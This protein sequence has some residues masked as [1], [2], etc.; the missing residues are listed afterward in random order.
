MS[1]PWLNFHW[2][3]DQCLAAVG[4][5]S[6]FSNFQFTIDSIVMDRRN[7]WKLP[8]DCRK[9]EGRQQ[10]HSMVSD[11]RVLLPGIFSTRFLGGNGCTATTIQELIRTCQQEV[12][13]KIKIAVKIVCYSLYLFLG[14]T[15][16]KNRWSF[17]CTVVTLIQTF[18]NNSLQK[19]LHSFRV[20]G[21]CRL[22][23][24]LTIR[25]SSESWETGSAK[26]S[27]L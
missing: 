22:Y 3:K 5:A 9:E 6:K 14:T 24:A 20:L 4:Q 26:T 17:I 23:D 12:A 18:L 19:F 10:S 8:L 11:V 15:H 13:R 2:W 1:H 27:K 16:L 21:P 7:S 25:I